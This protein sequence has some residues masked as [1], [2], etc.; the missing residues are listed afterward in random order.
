MKRAGPRHCPDRFQQLGIRHRPGRPLSS[1]GASARDNG[2]R[3]RGRPP[4]AADSHLPVWFAVRRR[5]R[6]AH[7]LGILRAKGA[8]GLG[9]GDL[10]LQ[11]LLPEQHLAEPAPSAARSR[12]S[13]RRPGGL[14]G[15]PRPQPGRCHTKQAARRPSPRASAGPSPIP[16]R[17]A[18]AAR[19]PACAAGTSARPGPIRPHSYPLSPSL[20]STSAADEVRLRGVPFTRGR[21]DNGERPRRTD[22]TPLRAYVTASL[23]AHQCAGSAL[24]AS[25][26]VQPRNRSSRKLIVGTA[27]A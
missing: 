19:P 20:W 12:A 21:G 11:Q 24:Q 8:A 6:L 26:A 3:S 17:A 23:K 22:A 5:G 15:P 27:A 14:R 1:L 13:R 4:D 9:G 2:R 25:R 7:R 18:A 10:L 16:R